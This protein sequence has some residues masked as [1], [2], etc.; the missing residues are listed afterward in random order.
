MPAK[1]TPRLVTENEWVWTILGISLLFGSAV[2]ILP[3]VLAGFPINDGGMFAVAMRDLLAN[4]FLPPAATTYNQLQIP[5][6]YPPLGFYAGALLQS[7]GLSETQVLLWLP[8]LLSIAILPAHYL[9]ARQLLGNRP[10]AAAA[11]AFFALTPGSY[12]WLIMGGGLTRSFG[13]LFFMGAVGFI[14]RAFKYGNKSDIAAATLFSAL[15]I[16]S[17][18]QYTL[19]TVTS[20]FVL[21]LFHGMSKQGSA[22]AALIAVSA[23][24]ASAPWWSGVAAAHG[25]GIFLSAGQAGDMRAS[26]TDLAKSIISIQTT[27]PL[28]TLF[29]IMGLGWL[30]YKKRFDLITMTA[31]PF[32]I[33][34]RSA[35]IVA[36]LIY[37]MFAAYGFLDALPALIR[38][39]KQPTQAAQ[40]IGTFTYNH[41][42]SI[43]LLGILFYLALECAVY[44]NVIRQ[45]VLPTPAQTMSAWVRENTPADSRFLIL[46]SRTDPMTDP[47][48]EWFPAL[49][50]RH[51]ATTLQGLEWTLGKNFSLRWRELAA[52]QACR[53]MPCLEL[54]EAKIGAN[55]DFIILDKSKTSPEIL[56]YFEEQ[57]APPL[58]EN[59]RYIVY[60]YK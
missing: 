32:F 17:H 19:L 21:W 54:R 58:Y 56:G 49:A 33:D 5:F 36:G 7:A 1:M 51:S 41:P 29:R 18:P 24:L 10:L 2:R 8:A 26:F 47:L 35:P 25:W 14:F 30:I 60:K 23:A 4:K 50:E 12:I 11:A 37:P 38:R 34:Q 53:D 6:A 45:V 28:L 27:V 55:S 3:G 43:S 46:T 42:L 9:F 57:G 16:L 39:L 59:I 22:S 40:P 20:G 44:T 15:V 48:Q 31:L 52:L 13:A